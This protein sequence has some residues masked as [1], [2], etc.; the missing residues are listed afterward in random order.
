MTTS[1]PDPTPH[2]D[3]SWEDFSEMAREEAAHRI[4]R[5]ALIGMVVAV[6]FSLFDLTED[7]PWAAHRARLTVNVGILLILTGLL[8]ALRSPA[9][10]RYV[11][12]VVFALC[13]TIMTVQTY[14]LA[15]ASAAQNRIAFHY[16]LVLGLC[17]IAVQWRWPW[18]LTLGA[19][20]VILFVGTVPTTMNDFAFFTV[21]LAAAGIMTTVV[22][23]V[24]VRRHYAQFA[25]ESELRRTLQ[26][27]N[28]S[29]NEQLARRAAEL[30]VANKELEAFTYSVSHDLRSPL[31]AIDGFSRALLDDY[32][33]QLDE[34]GVHYLD[35]VRAGTQRMGQLIDDLLRLSR[36]SRSDCRREPVDLTEIA[37]GTATELQNQE[38]TRQAEFLIPDGLAASGDPN[39]LRI[40]LE[41]L[42]GNAW[43]YTGKSP[44][45][46]IE[47]GTQP[48]TNGHPTF[49]V[50]DNGAGF[51][52]AYSSK[53]FGAFQ[54]L[55]SVKE[56]EGTGIGL[57]LV[58]RI[59]HRHGGDVWAEA[60]VGQGA[61]FY[62]TL[63]A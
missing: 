55:H 40:V 28:E 29:L 32:A 34:K 39:L 60:T 14:S 62:F 36:V 22:A 4:E 24:V 46:R 50:R 63:E 18:Q 33:G 54:R 37:R 42:L 23:H 48:S 45:A 15:Q 53:L 3:A 43:K 57:A 38:N 8:R 52:M 9:V 17:A 44:A 12:E 26:R 1:V 61:T 20:A 7:V 25:A 6:L 31:R 49:F 13:T 2:D 47:L 16:L 35:R 30:T 27:T 10:R 21:A 59:I 56:F 51:D 11:F 58:K 5:F 19:V 41:N